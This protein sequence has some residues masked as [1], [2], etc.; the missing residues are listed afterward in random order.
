MGGTGA[1]ATVITVGEV[2][3]PSQEGLNREPNL[4]V[5]EHYSWVGRKHFDLYPQMVDLLKNVWRCDRVTVDATGIGEPVAS[6][7]KR[8]LGS[9]VMPFVFSQKSKS[10]LAFELLAAINSGRLKLYAQDGSDD[11]REL[12]FE[13][14]RA[15]SHYRPN[16][17]LNFF[18]EPAEG[19]D[20]YL[21]SLALAVHAA[22][23][24]R[25]RL[26]K[27]RTSGSMSLHEPA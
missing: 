17:T 15:R 13:L 22:S 25:P 19:H 7:L 10:E 14:T 12:M 4:R 27:G 23:E 18:V 8:A 21:M 2:G 5:V 11:Y 9:R 1:D 3:L 6:F 16:Q 24:C 26:A 20:D